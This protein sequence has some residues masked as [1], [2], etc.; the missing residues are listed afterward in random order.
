MDNKD[1]IAGH[2]MVMFD[3]LS[4]RNIPFEE[5]VKEIKEKVWEMDAI[6]GVQFAERHPLWDKERALVLVGGRTGHVA[7]ASRRIEAIRA[8][9][10][11]LKCPLSW[12]VSAVNLYED[13]LLLNNNANN[14]AQRLALAVEFLQ[15]GEI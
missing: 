1:L 11:R 6:L 12:A 8:Y 14:E 9:R 2:L 4:E 7:S 5:I 13:F 15:R 3:Q 10:E